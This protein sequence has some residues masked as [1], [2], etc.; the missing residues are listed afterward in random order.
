MSRISVEADGYVRIL[1]IERPEHHNCIDGETAVALCEA[2]EAF[3]A[4]EA[5]RVLIVTGRGDAAF[6]SGADLRNTASL[7]SHAAL[8]R[9]GPL[10]FARLDPSKPVIGAING[11]AFAGGFELAAWCDF[12]IASK[13]AEFGVLNRRWGVPLIDGGTQRLPRIVGQGNALYLIETG[14]RID[15]ERALRMGFVQEVVPVGSALDRSIEIAQQI[16]QYPRA[17]LLAD[18]KGALASFGVGLDDGLLMERAF[19][20]STLSDPEMQAGLLRFVSPS[21][22]EAPRPAGV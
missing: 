16:A 6:C 9:A 14:M 22:P 8:E 13:N 11:Y 10:G 7:E 19:G 4:D 15:A 1:R 12:R 2:V 3:A 21:R 17:S 20:A 18:R 5:A